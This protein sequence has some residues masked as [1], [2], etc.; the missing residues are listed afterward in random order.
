MSQEP[1]IS[2]SNPLANLLAYQKILNDKLITERLL[3][4]K[5]GLSKIKIRA[6]E[7]HDNLSDLDEE[8]RYVRTLKKLIEEDLSDVSRH[9][10]DEASSFHRDINKIN[11]DAEIAFIEANCKD[12]FNDISKDGLANILRTV[13]ADEEQRQTKPNLLTRL[14]DLRGSGKAI[15]F[16]AIAGSIAATSGANIPVIIAG[17]VISQL[18]GP[19]SDLGHRAWIAAGD[20]LVN[21]GHIS[22]E[23]REM[24]D[25]SLNRAKDNIGKSK[26]WKIGKTLMISV[27][28][29]ALLGAGATAY[30]DLTSDDSM[31]KGL[32]SNKPDVDDAILGDLGEGRESDVNPSPGEQSSSD[33]N[34]EPNSEIPLQELNADKIIEKLKESAG[35]ERVIDHLGLENYTGQTIDKAQLQEIINSSGLSHE[36]AISHLANIN[37]SI[38]KE[39]SD[40]LNSPNESL[41]ASKENSNPESVEP[42]QIDS[43]DIVVNQGDTLSEILWGQMKDDISL[44]ELYN[45][46]IPAVAEHNGISNP[47]LIHPG[48]KITIPSELLAEYSGNQSLEASG[49]RGD[50]HSSPPE[51]TGVPF[52]GEGA[53][54][55]ASPS[56]WVK[57]RYL[58]GITNPEDSTPM[59]FRND[60]EGPAM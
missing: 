31:L 46:I 26:G 10:R 16:L 9:F 56:S 39:V 2:A 38:A 43:I 7:I 17:K 57:D 50:M 11:V 13:K 29:M 51:K 49:Q 22:Q 44:T 55:S 48:Q 8:D 34:K 12:A 41:I 60:D 21:K 24:I 5:E 52:K 19:A 45:E 3:S 35:G 14:R 40:V 54:Q 33:A 37:E 28:S 36:Q 30:F 47:D 59:I 6:L 20:A 32:L 23:R 58:N 25:A 4:E 15:S 53:E 1:K 18:T 27:G 42:P